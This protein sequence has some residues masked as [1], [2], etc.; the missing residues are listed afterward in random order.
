MKLT[1]HIKRKGKGCMYME[2]EEDDKNIYCS[3]C[4]HNFGS[5]YGCL[6]SRDDCWLDKKITK[7]FND[8]KH[9]PNCSIPNKPFKIKK[10]GEYEAECPKCKFH[11]SWK[12]AEANT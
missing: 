2:F 4:E 6:A 5:L 1:K 11:I 3:Y 10:I 7:P 12:M 8:H 9:C